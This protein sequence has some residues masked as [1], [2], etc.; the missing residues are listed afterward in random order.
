MNFSQ[1]IHKKWAL[2][3]IGPEMIHACMHACKKLHNMDQTDLLGQNCHFPKLP[4]FLTKGKGAN[5]VANYCVRTRKHQT[6]VL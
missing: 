3:F 2:P 4:L 1:C 5:L 6:Q